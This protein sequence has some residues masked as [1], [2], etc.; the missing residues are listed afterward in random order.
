MR[1]PSA[2]L[3]S[4]GWVDNAR[5][6]EPPG[7]SDEP[8]SGNAS[9][10][11]WSQPIRSGGASSCGM[12]SCRNTTAE[13]AR[14]C[15]SRWRGPAREG[16]ARSPTARWGTRSRALPYRQTRTVRTK[17]APGGRRCRETESAQTA[18]PSARR[19]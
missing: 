2:A 3:P 12:Q 18:R 5:T 15:S 1:V 11:D 10:A 4:L 17:D 14:S 8:A 6:I 13:T 19:A 16:P 9:E 7:R